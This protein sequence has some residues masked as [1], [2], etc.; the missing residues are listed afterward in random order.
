MI[1][2]E[3]PDNQFFQSSFLASQ[4]IH[5]NKAFRNRV[6]QVFFEKVKARGTAGRASRGLPT[7]FQQASISFETT[8]LTIFLPATPMVSGFSFLSFV[9]VREIFRDF[10]DFSLSTLVLLLAKE[11]ITFFSSIGI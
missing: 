5:E 11:S 8:S 2:L 7:D 9:L 10:D 4:E 6:R 3:P 1:Q